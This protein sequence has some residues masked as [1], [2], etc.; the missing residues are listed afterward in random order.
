MHKIIHKC[1]LKNVKSICDENKKIY[2]FLL[3]G[4]LMILKD[5]G[6]IRKLFIY[7]LVKY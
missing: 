6:E 7:F 2:T 3:N 5:R 1:G 4:P